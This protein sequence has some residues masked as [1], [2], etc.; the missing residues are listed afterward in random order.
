M[1]ENKSQLTKTTHMYCNMTSSFIGL[2]CSSRRI[3]AAG[4]LGNHGQT[5]YC[6]LK[7]GH[8]YP[9]WQVAFGLWHVEWKLG[10]S[11]LQRFTG[12][13]CAFE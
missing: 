3:L 12:F 6:T 2:N 13:S 1:A 4:Q 5:L 8:E 9:L 10:L 11:W 7:I